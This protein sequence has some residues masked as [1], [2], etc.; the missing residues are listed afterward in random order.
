[1]EKYWFFFKKQEVSYSV[2]NS[3]R[4]AGLRPTTLGEDRKHF[5]DFS[6]VLCLW[7]QIKGMRTYNFFGL[8]SN[9]GAVFVLG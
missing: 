3:H 8:L 5:I 4:S 7:L 1:M 2:G 6:S 9:T